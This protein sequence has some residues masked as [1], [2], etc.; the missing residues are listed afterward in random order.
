[1]I[2]Q[3]LR[4]DFDLAIVSIF[5]ILAIVGITPFAVYRYLVGNQAAAIMD[6]IIV[7]AISAA[8]AH[9][10]ISG[11]A[12]RAGVFLTVATNLGCI[13]SAALLG[14]AGL[15]WT[16][17]VLLVNFLLLSR[18]TAL[19]V[20]VATLTVLV[21]HGRAFENTLEVAMFLVTA[22]VVSLFAFIFASRTESQRKQ[23]EALVLSDSLTGAQNRRAMDQE[24]EIAVKSFRRDPRPYGL[25]IFDLDHFKRIN[26]KYGHE[27]GDDVLI[28]F[29]D[30]VRTNSRK[31]DRF[32]RMGGEEFVLLIPGADADSLRTIVENHRANIE[33][34]L[35][36]RDEIITTSIGATLL[37]LGEDRQEWLARADAALY[38][39]KKAGRNCVIV[40]I[41]GN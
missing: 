7:I 32:F 9:A 41:G 36:Y 17:P 24:L 18:R 34:H 11:N 20:C 5:A 2:W 13:S 3:R 25:A 19:L 10:W 1:M 12:K 37:K 21:V 29:A 23:L 35:R 26:D 14:L 22:S 39:A 30:L 27:E 38:A 31:M 33:D 40:D 15:F 8:L 28:Q 16:F 6:V 4:N